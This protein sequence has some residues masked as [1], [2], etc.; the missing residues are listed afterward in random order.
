MDMN[1]VPGKSRDDVLIIDVVTSA[2]PTPTARWEAAW[3]KLKAQ[4]YAQV[5]EPWTSI[6]AGDVSGSLGDL[7]TFL[8]LTVRL[9]GPN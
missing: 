8:P 4:T 7:G 3:K 1:D 5:I 6:S 2:A 9:P